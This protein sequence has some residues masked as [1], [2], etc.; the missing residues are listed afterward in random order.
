LKII[1]VKAKEETVLYWDFVFLNYKGEQMLYC[2]V[3]PTFN[4]AYKSF[5]KYIG[6]GEY[7]L[8]SCSTDGTRYR[9]Q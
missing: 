4:L 3:A 8:L 2:C 1:N 5:L 6:V 9:L 7:T